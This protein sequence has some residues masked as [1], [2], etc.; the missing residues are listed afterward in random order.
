MTVD[1]RA[2]LKEAGVDVSEV[3]EWAEALLPYWCV[4]CEDEHDWDVGRGYSAVDRELAEQA[5]AAILALARLVAKYKYQRDLCSVDLCVAV[6]D[7]DSRSGSSSL[8]IADL[9]RRW[10]EQTS[11]ST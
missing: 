1:P 5:S 7:A 2:I 10:E 3:E 6:H 4:D 9:D 8:V 11:C